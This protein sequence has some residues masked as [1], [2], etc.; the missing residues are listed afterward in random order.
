MLKYLVNLD[1]YVTL[2]VT[3]VYPTPGPRR[4]FDGVLS[5]SKF[6]VAVRA[7]VVPKSDQLLESDFSRGSVHSLLK[8]GYI[9]LKR[10]CGNKV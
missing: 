2:W 5:L 7:D 3:S 6:C 4:R 9:A 8:L 10:E 1:L